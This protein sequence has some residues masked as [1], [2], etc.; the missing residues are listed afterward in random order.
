MTMEVD[1]VNNTAQRVNYVLS[2]YDNLDEVQKRKLTELLTQLALKSLEQNSSWFQVIDK[3]LNGLIESEKLNTTEV[4]NLT[5]LTTR[6]DNLNVI[7]KKEINEWEKTK[8]KRQ[9]THQM[10]I[11][12]DQALSNLLD[13]AN[14]IV[15]TKQSNTEV[16]QS[17]TEVKQSN[18]EVKEPK[19]EREDL[20]A[21]ANSIE[22]NLKS[23]SSMLSKRKENQNTLENVKSQGITTQIKNFLAGRDL[24]MNYST[25]T[26]IAIVFFF[27][28][29]G[30]HIYTQK[31]HPS[32]L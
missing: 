17:N 10:L 5:L 13:K 25:A 11:S 9:E 32:N 4:E 28:G 14:S 22:T 31:H 27:C 30:C 16:K 20:L 7:I 18:T 8:H 2:L 6:I 19:K 15:E 3:A 23:L 12:Q 26:K 24:K 29:L 1:A 21:L